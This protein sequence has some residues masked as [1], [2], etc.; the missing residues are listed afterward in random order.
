MCLGDQL[1]S[2][3]WSYPTTAQHNCDEDTYDLMRIPKKQ[4]QGEKN[5]TVTRIFMRFNSFFP[6][7]KK[8]IRKF[9]KMSRRSLNVKKTKN[10][11]Q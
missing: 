11:Y 1:L 10:I 9:Q 8:N 3:N 5:K 7:C 2:L 6:S 4:N